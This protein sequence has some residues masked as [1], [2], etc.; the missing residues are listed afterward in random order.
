MVQAIENLT[1]I[2]GHILARKAHPHLDAYDIVTLQLE[3]TASV[4]EKADLLTAQTGTTIEVSVRRELLKGAQIGARL[5]CRAKRT[6]D[7]AMCE[8]HPEPADI[9][10][11][12]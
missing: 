4:P 7:G 9:E 3:R 12:E 1:R 5:R 10:I 8:P 6:P 2:E 11:V